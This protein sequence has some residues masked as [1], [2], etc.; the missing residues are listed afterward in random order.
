MRK[1]LILSIV[2]IFIGSGLS[3]AQR[4]KLKRYEV[5]FGVGSANYFGDIGGTP[6]QTNLFGLKDVELGNTRPSVIVGVRYKV[7]QN[8]SVKFTFLYG[9]ITGQ[10]AGSRNYERD[11]SFSSP[12]YE[13]SIQVEYYFIPEEKKFRSAALFNRRGMINNYSRLSAYAF[14]GAGAVF[15]NPV[16]SGDLSNRAPEEYTGYGK[17]T[18]AVPLGIGIKYVFDENWSMALDLGGRW[19]ATDYLDGFASVWSKN[20]D[21]YYFSVLQMVYKIKTDRRGRPMI[22]NRRR[23]F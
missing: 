7:E 14:A 23:N 8:I 1:Y 10:D 19:T 2:L 17:T 18:L 21:V 3:R 6:D 12:L 20:N 11:L 4:W 9:N 16:L 5:M 13:P 22:F 15:F